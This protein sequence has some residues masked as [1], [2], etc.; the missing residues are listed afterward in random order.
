MQAIF[1]RCLR[2]TRELKGGETHSYQVALVQPNVSMPQ[3][4]QQGIDLAIDVFDPGD[5]KIADADS[6]NDNWGVEP[7]MLVASLSGNYRVDIRSPNKTALTGRY[8]IKIIASRKATATD[9]PMWLRN[10]LSTKAERCEP[11]KRLRH[12]VPRSKNTNKHCLS[13]VPQVNLTVR[14]LHFFPLA[15]PTLS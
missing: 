14:P 3:V 11:S 7:I 4:E 2:C 6:P 10:D 5:Q 8:E 13:S 12:D 1:H 15:S 9:Q